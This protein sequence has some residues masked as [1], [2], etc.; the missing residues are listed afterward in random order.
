MEHRRVQTEK[1]QKEKTNKDG[2]DN[3]GHAG[4]REMRERGRKNGVG[5][6]IIS[7][8]T[9]PVSTKEHAPQSEFILP[10]YRG[11]QGT[12]PKGGA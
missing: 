12:S 9:R 4:E 6:L 10:E 2:G 11:H 3:D 8:N 7:W 5:L 1:K